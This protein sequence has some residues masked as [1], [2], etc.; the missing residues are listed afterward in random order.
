M[1]LTIDTCTAAVYLAG[2]LRNVAL[3]F[4]GTTDTRALNLSSSDPKF[5]QLERFLNNLRISIPTS[6]GRRTKTIRGLI[7]RAGKFEFSKNDGQESTVA[8]HFQETYNIRI[9]YSEIFGVN[10]S[11]KNNP[12]PSVIPAELCEVIPGQ[13]YKRKVPEYLTAKVVDFAKIKPQDRFRKISQSAEAYRRSE[14][15]VES[16]M[17]I[18][19]QPLQ[20]NARRLNVP[21]VLY[22]VGNSVNV[23]D[24][25]WNVVGKQFSSP[26][27]F[28]SW[29]VI[30]FVGDKLT[31][32]DIR[33]RVRALSSCCQQL[34]MGRN[35]RSP[36][37]DRPGQSPLTRRKS[38]ETF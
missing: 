6:N 31:M 36:S 10:I 19:T 4:L 3:S 18:D 17:Q 28:N 34:G 5:K 33:D 30:D 9:R 35:F 27:T 24:G 38:H 1:I 32:D 15:V 37:Y 21:R 8:L 16:G 22:G 29:A 20:I 11:G 25:G 2:D 14:F 12:H 13:L 23:R 7:E 26:K